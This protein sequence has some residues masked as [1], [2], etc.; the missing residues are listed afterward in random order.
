M[1]TYRKQY[2]LH[3]YVHYAS[4]CLKSFYIIIFGILYIHK[5]NIF[6]ISNKTATTIL[7]KEKLR[8]F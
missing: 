1:Y 7:V 3:K 2:I 6:T 8:Y 5:A 4:L